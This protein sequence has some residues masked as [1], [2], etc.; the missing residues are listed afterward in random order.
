[1][2]GIGGLEEQIS[3]T[4]QSSSAAN[5]SEAPVNFEETSLNNSNDVVLPEAFVSGGQ[6]KTSTVGR[7]AEVVL[8]EERSL[9]ACIVRTIPAGGRIRISSTVSIFMSCS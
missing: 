2:N 3:T 8:L 9:L 6:T 1:M 4:A 7:T 5:T